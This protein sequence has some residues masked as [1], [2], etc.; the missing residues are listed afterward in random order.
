[1]AE[2]AA[3]GIFIPSGPIKS[4]HGATGGLKWKLWVVVPGQSKA[5]NR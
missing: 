1:M 2:I 3:S 4:T 5:K